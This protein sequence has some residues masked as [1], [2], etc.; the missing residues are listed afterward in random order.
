MVFIR[1][2][3]YF[4]PVIR[5]PPEEGRLFGTEAGDLAV[6]VGSSHSLVVL[7]QDI[8]TP[9]APISSFTIEG[10]TQFFDSPVGPWDLALCRDL[11]RGR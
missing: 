8:G 11:R 4:I 6:P 3:V 7:G 10:L 9:S 2:S 5:C 1:A